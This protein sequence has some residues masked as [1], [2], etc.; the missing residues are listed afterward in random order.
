MRVLSA[1]LLLVPLTA[2]SLP[3]EG[4]DEGKV[5]IAAGF[6]PLAWVSEQV[7]GDRVDVISLTQPGVEPH[8]L[9]LTFS[10]TVDLARADLVVYESG[11]QPA[12]DQGV[13]QDAEGI[14]IDA[15]HV[16]ELHPIED[17]HEHSHEGEHDDH[18]AADPHFWLDPTLLADVADEVADQLVRLDPTQQSTY[19]KNAEALKASLH[20]L[21]TAFR[22]GLAECARDTIVAS[23]DAFGYWEKYDVHVE[24]VSGLSP[25]AEPTPAALQRLHEL[26]TTDHITTVFNER[27]ASPEL[28][29]S[30]ADDLGLTTAILDP[31]EGLTSETSTEDY[32]SLMNDNLTALQEANACAR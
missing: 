23:H 7:G 30:L 16:V 18:G 13:E 17:E 14:I 1:L 19:R 4:Y 6:Y 2:C 28:T 22:L 8:D 32:L 3:A 20:E 5:A 27:L 26:I 11:F 25:D 9:E 31:I 24:P 21:D 12:V 10:A 15:A 29:R